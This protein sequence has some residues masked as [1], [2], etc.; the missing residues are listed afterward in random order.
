MSMTGAKAFAHDIEVTN[1]DGVTIYYNWINDK[2]EL[3]VTYRGIYYYEF[4]EYFDNNINLVFGQ[5][6]LDSINLDKNVPLYYKFRSE[7]YKVLGHKD[8]SEKDIFQY[9]ILVNK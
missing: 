3:E 6:I 4:D 8:L 2:T 9:N 5:S 1:A 7:V